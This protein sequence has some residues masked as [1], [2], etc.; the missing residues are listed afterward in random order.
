[1]EPGVWRGD[2]GGGGWGGGIWSVK[3]KSTTCFNAWWMSYSLAMLMSL[4]LGHRC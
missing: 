3:K 4:H 2:M 1:M